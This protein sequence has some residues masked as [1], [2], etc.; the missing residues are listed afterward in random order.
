[1]LFD[2]NSS[3]L[4]FRTSLDS[5]YRNVFD[6]WDTTDNYVKFLKEAY[7]GYKTISISTAKSRKDIDGGFDLNLAGYSSM[8]LHE[9]NYLVFRNNND[10]KFAFI[11]SI[12]SQNDGPS[13][14][15]EVKLVCK[16]DAWSNHYLEM[17]ECNAL[18]KTRRCTYDTLARKNLLS[19]AKGMKFPTAIS[20]YS[21]L[22]YRGA[23]NTKSE[24]AVLWQ[25]IVLSDKPTFYHGDGTGPFQPDGDELQI[26]GAYVV[27]K[28]VAVARAGNPELLK[29]ERIEVHGRTSTSTDVLL[30]YKHQIHLM[31]IANLTSSFVVS[32]ELTYNVPFRY[33]IEKHT[34]YDEV[35]LDSIDG[36]YVELL[37]LADIYGTKIEVNTTTIADNVYGFICPS[38]YLTN[39]PNYSTLINPIS[40]SHNADRYGVDI[41]RACKCEQIFSE[42]PFNYKSVIISGK[43]V[44]LIGISGT[45][46]EYGF[47]YDIRKKLNPHILIRGNLPQLYTHN[48]FVAQSI[49]P[50]GSL[51]TRNLAY[52]EY[53]MKNANSID[54]QKTQVIANAIFSGFGAFK[55]LTHGAISP[56]IFQGLVNSQIQYDAINASL[57]DLKNTS[58]SVFNQGEYATDNPTVLDSIILAERTIDLPNNSEAFELLKDYHYNGYEVELNISLFDNSKDVFDVIQGQCQLYALMNN[59]DRAEIEAAV[60]RGITKWHCY[61]DVSSETDRDSRVW[62]VSTMN[63]NCTNFNRS[64]L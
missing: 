27:Y 63:K 39:E 29:N 25:R 50:T 31:N 64:E 19:A 61:V 10:Y 56:S 42:Y 3:I 7:P 13:T 26:G 58:S 23:D 44:P 52:D 37:E 51:I 14:V 43:E 40:I 5:N 32:N 60:S 12:I 54:M 36:F 47:I 16:L 22:P 11:T 53:M 49:A 34:F 8:D 48:E 55:A 45:T 24:Y 6:D 35:S 57:E 30:A 17:K 28:P 18:V 62:I 46:G 15:K 9:Y 33:T 59:D 38:Y 1:M 4:L 21:Y 20:G 41:V 2:S